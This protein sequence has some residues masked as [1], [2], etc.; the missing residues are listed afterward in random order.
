VLIVQDRSGSMAG[1]N[2]TAAKNAIKGILDRNLLS[3]PESRIRYGLNMYPGNG[4]DCAAGTWF[5]H[6]APGTEQAIRNALDASGTPGCT[7]TAQTFESILAHPAELEDPSRPNY[8]IHVTD[9]YPN[10]YND[11]PCQQHSSMPERVVTAVTNLKNQKNITTFVVGFTS[12]VNPAHLNQVAVAG[13]APRPGCDPNSGDANP[14]YYRASNASE[15]AQALDTIATIIGGQFS[16]GLACDET[17]YGQG[18]PEG[19]LCKNAACVPDPCLSVTCGAGEYCRDGAC[20]KACMSPCPPGTMCQ[21]GECVDDRCANVFCHVEANEVC[22]NGECIL[23]PCVA[24]WDGGTEARC[25][26]GQTCLPDGTC[27]DDP[28]NF[29]TC[30]E[31]TVCVWGQCQSTSAFVPPQYD[32]GTGDGDGGIDGGTPVPDGGIGDGGSLVGDGG[33]GLNTGNSGCGCQAAG[34]TGAGLLLFLG[35]VCLAWRRRDHK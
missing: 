24:R 1:T 18:C 7:P 16:G 3:P 10:C 19:E 5:V 30:P 25:R 33:T 12:G 32:G 23:D 14:C 20:V 9:G 22:R 35:L 21:N 2:W 17:C 31:G 26:Y 4:G 28:C 11:E 27:G 29:I 6:P 8:I 13:G 15:L 34:S